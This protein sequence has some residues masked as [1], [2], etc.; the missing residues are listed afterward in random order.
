MKKT[1]LATFVLL[2]LCIC[3]FAAATGYPG[4]ILQTP[5]GTLYSLAEPLPELRT[6]EIDGQIYYYEVN[7]LLVRS[8]T[9]ECDTCDLQLGNRAP[10]K[11]GWYRYSV[12]HHQY[13][14]YFYAN[15]TVCDKLAYVFVPGEIAQ[16]NWKY[17][18]DGHAWDTNHQ[19][20]DQCRV[21]NEVMTS[22]VFCP[23]PAGGGCTVNPG[24]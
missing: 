4:Q 8:L 22:Y 16:H 19:I 6:V 14:S 17:V 9:E 12:T 2:V 5:T 18:S 23:G 10:E 11:D 20:V 13:R 15:C 3:T 24:K 21:C 1:A 7:P